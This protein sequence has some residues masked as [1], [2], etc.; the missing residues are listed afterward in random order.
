[1]PFRP[2]LLVLAAFA[3]AL[4][5]G[6]CLSDDE[7]RLGTGPAGTP[8]SRFNDP[9]VV[10]NLVASAFEWEV[11]PG[12]KV[13]VWGYNKSYPG[14]TI[15][16]TKGD[17]VRVTLKNELPE[18]TTIHWHGF[19][20]PWDQDGVDGLSQPAIK[21]GESWTY[22]FIARES[23]T[24]MYHSHTNSMEQVQ[25]G[26]FGALIV[27]P[28]RD[29][30][31][32]DHEF[33]FGLHEIEGW[34]TING[35][36]FPATMEKDFMRIK[37]GDKALIRMYNAG[38]VNHPMHLHGHQF[39]VVAVDGNKVQSPFRQNTYD[40]APGMVVDVVIQGDNPGT[41]MFHCH[42]LP[43]TTNRGVY[44]G[45]M[46][47]MLDYTDHTS[48]FDEQVA[49]GGD[50][51]GHDMHTPTPQA[52]ATPPAQTA[53]PAQQVRVIATE[54]S[55]SP[56]TITVKVNEPVQITLQNSGA[57]VHNIAITNPRFK[58]EAN[59]GQTRSGT[60]TFTQPG[61]YEFIC[62]I[63]GHANL[64]MRGTITVQ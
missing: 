6:A 43:H 38:Q 9:D 32:Y 39:E 50:T 17:K 15:T 30:E 5:F 60:V 2:R 64:G 3:A 58:V 29:A 31:H 41:W 59:A 54:Y 13:Q 1:M 45:G 49:S 44:P 61:T 18:A 22:E 7:A 56:S 37:T 24:H 46:V 19:D 33:V 63:P 23:G 8:G 14:P 51:G 27:K 28:R 47:L 20:V 40:L 4:A 10:V 35:H 55:F 11:I 21:P 57:I 12:E 36:S 42:T 26:L 52:T 48:Y 53:V 34:F 25:K 16:A 62:D